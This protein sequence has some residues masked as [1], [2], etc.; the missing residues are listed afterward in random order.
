MEIFK[1]IVLGLVQGLTEF[2]PVSSTAHLI[3]FPWFFGWGGE[4]DTLSF[5]VALHGGTLFALIAYFWKDWR[6]LL[7][8]DHKMLMLV[9]IGTV[10]AGIAGILLQKWV[11]HALRSPIIIVFTLV[12]VGFIMLAAEKRGEQNRATDGDV[13]LKD[14]VIIG[15]A[16]AVALI[17]GVSRSGIT[18]TAGLFSGLTRETATRFSFLLSTPIIA[19]ATL[20]HALKMAKNHESFDMSLVGAGFVAAAVSGFFAIGFLMNYLRKHPLHNFVYYRFAL[21]AVVLIAWL[22]HG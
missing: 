3:L 19:G 2:F 14:A 10:P 4:L 15:C 6:N 22:L 7:L 9:I 13:T 18:I 8:K 1:A 21:A 17:P 12:G 11:E 5:D 20:L 16:Q